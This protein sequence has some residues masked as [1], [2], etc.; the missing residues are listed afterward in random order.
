MPNWWRCLIL[1]IRWKTDKTLKKMHLHTKIFL[2]RIY[3]GRKPVSISPEEWQVA[4]SDYYT[5]KINK[6]QMANRLGISR[7]ILDKLLKKVYIFEW[8]LQILNRLEP[9]CAA[10]NMAAHLPQSHSK[11]TAVTQK[12]IR[13]I[14]NFI[15]TKEK[16]W[17]RIGS[18]PRSYWKI[19]TVTT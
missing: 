7:T 17:Q 16:I 15:I 1:Q 6:V 13:W 2:M 4:Y 19:C 14:E 9:E 8:P 18:I 11:H 12:K 3:K 5:R 10:T